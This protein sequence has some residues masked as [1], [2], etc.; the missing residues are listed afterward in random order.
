MKNKLITLVVPEKNMER[1]FS[2]DH[3]ERLLNMQNNGGWQKKQDANSGG[4]KSKTGKSS[5]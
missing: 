1:Q 4:N 5:E 2:L 3:A